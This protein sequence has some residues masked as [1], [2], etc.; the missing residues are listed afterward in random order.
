MSKGMMNVASRVSALA[1]QNGY[2][3]RVSAFAAPTPVGAHP[4]R[5]ALVARRNARNL[6]SAVFF[7]PSF[8]FWAYMGKRKSGGGSACFLCGV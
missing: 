5:V 6:P 3:P 4:R 8:F 2:V 7:L 1:A